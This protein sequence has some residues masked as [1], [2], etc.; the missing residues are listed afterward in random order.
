MIEVGD[1]VQFKTEGLPDQ[2]IDPPTTAP[3]DT[4]SW[5]AYFGGRPGL[6]DTVHYAAGVVRVRGYDKNGNLFTVWIAPEHLTVT[7]GAMDFS[8]QSN[9]A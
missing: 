1:R 9:G 4:V 2:V 3:G 7:R 5:Q 8:E 6:V